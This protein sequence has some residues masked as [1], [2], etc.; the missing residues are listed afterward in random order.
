VLYIIIA[1]LC[2]V[3]LLS[4]LLSLAA[5]LRQPAPYTFCFG[6]VLFICLYGGA[7]NI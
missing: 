1:V 4:L 5:A 3:M 2:S 6:L 7:M